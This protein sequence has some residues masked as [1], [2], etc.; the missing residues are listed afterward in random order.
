[1]SGNVSRKILNF[2]VDYYDNPIFEC[3][4]Q[5]VDMVYLQSKGMVFREL[6]VGVFEVRKE[7]TV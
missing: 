1:M 6:C 2:S 4:D 5:L 7:R 3:G